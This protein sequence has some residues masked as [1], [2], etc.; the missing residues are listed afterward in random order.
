M[1]GTEI[2][3]GGP[4]TKGPCLKVTEPLGEVI[5]D[6]AKGNEVFRRGN[7]YIQVIDGIDHVKVVGTKLI[8]SCAGDVG[9]LQ[10]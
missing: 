6:N 3:A 4:I 2:G 8:P 10:E 1:R 7:G 5:E 9:G